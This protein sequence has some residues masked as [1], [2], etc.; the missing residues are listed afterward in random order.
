MPSQITKTIIE[1]LRHMHPAPEWAIFAELRS[2]TG[3]SAPERYIDFYAISLWKKR[4][5]AK[6]AYEIK[7]TRGDFLRELD[8]PSKRETAED[9]ADECYFAMPVGL[10]KADEMPESWGLIELKSN[11]L[12]VKKRAMQKEIEQSLPYPFI[13]SLARRLSDP[14]STLEPALWLR[15]GQELDEESLLLAA[16]PNLEAH[17]KDIE[18]N[19]VREFR[20]GDEFA[21]LAAAQG[22][23]T[24]SLGWRYTDPKLL[25]EWFAENLG[26]PKIELDW[27]VKNQLH[28]LRKSIDAILE[29]EE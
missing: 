12:R 21:R 15:L 29:G 23:I 24:K 14:E 11:G 19:A 8:H 28:A 17:D 22:V 18:R 3:Y 9:V 4:R 10:V 1:L 26:K 27:Q 7:S 6:I 2:C 13:L 5:Y 25:A 20:K 16:A